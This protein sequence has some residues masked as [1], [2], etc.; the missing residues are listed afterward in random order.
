MSETNPTASSTLA[1]T[2]PLPPDAPIPYDTASPERRAEIE[3]TMSEIELEDSSSILFFGSAAQESVTAVADEM[4]EGV[5]NK[6]TAAAGDALNDMITTLR[7]L[8]VGDLDAGKKPGFAARLFRRA[9]PIA[10]ALQ[11]YE[12]VRSQ[13]DAISNRL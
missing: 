8:P 4:L 9:T 11:R 10:R 2:S 6:Q 3:K 12:H 1:A 5:R 7:G 13:V